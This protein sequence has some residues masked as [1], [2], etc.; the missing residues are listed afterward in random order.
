MNPFGVL[1]ESIG[2]HTVLVVG[3]FANSLS[4]ATHSEKFELNISTYKGIYACGKIFKV[5]LQKFQTN[6]RTAWVV[7]VKR[8]CTRPVVLSRGARLTRGTSMN[9]QRESINFQG[10]QAFALNA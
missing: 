5:L 2:Q 3:L 1:T 7:V 6:L 4:E 10:A 8:L 9:F